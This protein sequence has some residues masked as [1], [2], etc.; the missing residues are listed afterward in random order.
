LTQIKINK[1]PFH[2][3]KALDNGVSRDEFGRAD[4]PRSGHE[5]V[6]TVVGIGR[7]HV[8]TKK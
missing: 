3:G 4:H 1:H 7:I 2:L 8:A 5:H 6:R